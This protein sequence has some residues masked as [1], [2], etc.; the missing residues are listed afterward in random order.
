MSTTYTREKT[1]QEDIAP[2][3]EEALPGVDVL[4]VEL[5]SPSR[6]CVYV[7]HPDGVDHALC[8]RVTRLLDDYRDDFTI[9]VSS[10]GPERPLRKREHFAAAE[11]R[12]ASVRTGAAV[13]GRRKFKGEIG[14]ADESTFTLTTSDEDVRIPYDEIVRANLIDEGL[15]T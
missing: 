14:E 3:V 13:S 7:D 15:T 12:R 9:D 4:A 2:R 11:G 1:L 10:P 5:I 8:E 6:F